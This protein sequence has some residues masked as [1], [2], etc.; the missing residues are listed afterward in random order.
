MSCSFAF[1]ASV[2]TTVYVVVTFGVVLV[3]DPETVDNPA[4]GL[5]K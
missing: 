4:P 5:H 1:N 3:D 2:A